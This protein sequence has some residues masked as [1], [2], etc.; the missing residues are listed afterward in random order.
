MN[1][2]AISNYPEQTVLHYRGNPPQLRYTPT[3]DAASRCRGNPSLL[4]YTPTADAACCCRGNTLQRR[5]SAAE[6]GGDHSRDCRNRANHTTA[7][8]SLGSQTVAS[9]PSSWEG[10]L[11]RHRKIKPEPPN[12]EHLRKKTFFFNELC[13]SRIKHSSLTAL[14][15]QQ[16]SQLSN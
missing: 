14:N 8:R 11:I 10:H 9:L 1:K 16:S 4:R 13:C 6:H 2:T 12:T 5:D 7:G 15:E 3:A